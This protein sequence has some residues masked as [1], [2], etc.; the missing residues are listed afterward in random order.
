MVAMLAAELSLHLRDSIN[1]QLVMH[2]QQIENLRIDQETT[3]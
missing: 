1:A 3:Q 2:Q